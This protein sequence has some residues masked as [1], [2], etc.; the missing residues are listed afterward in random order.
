MNRLNG[1]GNKAL[2]Q[3]QQVPRPHGNNNKGVDT[4]QRHFKVLK[5]IYM[6]LV[7]CHCVLKD[8]FYSETVFLTQH[9]LL[10]LFSSQVSM[11]S[12]V[13]LLGAWIPHVELQMDT[14]GGKQTTTVLHVTPV[15]AN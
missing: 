6:P 3:Y 10:A 2:C 13:T 14:F 12:E 4:H 15:E 11:T 7:L 5:K 1:K 9:L 8:E